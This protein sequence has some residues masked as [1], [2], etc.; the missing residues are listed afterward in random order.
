KSMIRSTFNFYGVLLALLLQTSVPLLAQQKAARQQGYGDASYASPQEGQYLMRWLLSDPV[1]IAG[2][3]SP[4][5]DEVQQK[6]FKRDDDLR[7]SVD[8]KGGVAPLKIDSKEYA[9]RHYSSKGAIIN[10]DSIY[11]KDFAYC[12]ALAEV[13]S[14]IPQKRMLAVGSDD[15]VRGWVNG[16]LVH[17]NWKPRGLV[18]DEDVFAVV[19]NKGSNQVLIK[20][21]D[22]TQDWGFSARFLDVKSLSTR[23]PQASA[24]G[25]QDLVTEVID[26]GADVN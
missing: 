18:P 10:L 1:L 9:W 13:R 19:L 11:K 20:T 25:D 7:L 6:I 17:S 26:A 16:T 24:S 22:I 15:G 21:Q 4:V 12:Y 3:E 8:A 5:D 2:G 23:L 14:D